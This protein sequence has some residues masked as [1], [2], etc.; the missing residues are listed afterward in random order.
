MLCKMKVLKKMTAIVCTIALAASVMVG[1][2]KSDTK[3]A[4]G[5]SDPQSSKPVD[6]K[7]ILPYSDETPADEPILPALNKLCNANI[8]IEWTPMISYGDKFNVIMA[9]NELPDALDV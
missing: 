8:K 6:V 9:S 4:S 1:C 5:T 2:S 7:L 3:S